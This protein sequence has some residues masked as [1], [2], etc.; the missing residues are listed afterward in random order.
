[1]IYKKPLIFAIFSLS[2]CAQAQSLTSRDAG[3]P[4]SNS[5]SIFLNQCSVTPDWLPDDD[6]LGEESAPGQFDVW[7]DF[8]QVT[9]NRNALYS[10]NVALRQQNQWLLTESAEV[11]QFTGEIKAFDGIRY[12]DGYIAI[13]AQ[14]INADMERQIAHVGEAEYVLLANS[15]HGRA[16]SIDIDAQDGQRRVSLGGSSFTTC[17][18][19]NPAWQIVAED[20]EMSEQSSWGYRAEILQF[21]N[22]RCSRALYPSSLSFSTYRREEKLGFNY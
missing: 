19:D 10:G 9:G 18:G 17:P 12:G 3:A 7:A 2:V 11:D 20:I 5:N 14:E 4:P 8:A 21:S 22:F 1:M 15:A 13:R 6:I 16:Q